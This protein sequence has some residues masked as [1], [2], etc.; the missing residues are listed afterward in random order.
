MGARTVDLFL[1]GILIGWAIA[2]PVGPVNVLCIRRTLTQGW[3]VGFTSGCGAAVADT[4]YGAVAAFG[5]SF[6]SRFLLDHELALRLG[7]GVALCALGVRSLRHVPVLAPAAV[8][9][10]SLARAFLSAL[11]LTL[12]NPLVLLTIGAVFAVVGLAD[13]ELDR[14]AAELVVAGVLSGSMLWWVTITGSVELL[15]SRFDERMLRRVGLASGLILLLA[16]LAVLASALL[17]LPAGASRAAQRPGPSGSVR[18]SAYTP[19]WS[20]GQ[21]PSRSSSHTTRQDSMRPTPF[22]WG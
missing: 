20:L 8:R 14:P 18:S 1:S 11:L 13:R 9:A 10:S 7:G 4:F 17:V 12:S 16:G 2:V 22:G 3:A 21:T 19:K 15:R 5:I 6:V